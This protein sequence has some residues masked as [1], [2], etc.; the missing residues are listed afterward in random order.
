MLKK[1]GW[2]LFSLLLIS[3]MLLASCEKSATET[4]TGTT[5]TGTTTTTTTTGTTTTTTTPTGPEMVKTSIGTMV[6]KPQYGG[7]YY[8]CSAADIYGFDN[9]Y[10]YPYL[11]ST[12]HNTNEPLMAGDW[13]KGPAGTG[14]VTWTILGVTFMKFSK[15]R[16]AESWEKPDDQTLIIRIRKGIH[17]QNKPP[18]NGRELD[19]YDVEFSL[20][21][22]FT[23]PGSYL[24]LTYRGADAPTSLKATDQWTVEIKCNPG[25]LGPLFIVCMGYIDIFPRDGVPAGGN[26]KDWTASNGTGP[27][28]IT[29]YVPNSSCTMVKNPDYWMTDPLIP[30]N[31]LPY[32]DKTLNLVMPDESMRVAALKTGKVDVLAVPWDVAQAIHKTNPD[33]IEG[34]YL[35][36]Y[37]YSIKMQLGK[38]FP[39][40]DIKVRYAL[41]MA[42]DRQKIKD[43]F[44]G[45]N[46]T[47]F[48]FPVM[49]EPELSGMFTPL[50]ELP[51]KVQDLFKHDV[52][53]AKQLMAEAGQEKGFE[54]E[55]IVTSASQTQVDLLSLIASMWKDINVTLNVKPLENAVFTSQANAKSFKHMIYNYCGN[56]APYKMNDWRPLNPNNAGNID[57]PQLVEVY[58]QL[59]TLYPFDEAGAMA[60][61]KAQTPYILE[62]CWEI[63]PPLADVFWFCQPW[64]KNYHGEVTCGYYQSTNCNMFRWI[65]QKLK[66]QLKK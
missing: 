14:D 47:D 65:D 19:A 9:A 46:A 22:C 66:T 52:T 11:L 50:S 32:I 8:T 63:T 44:Y 16:V 35:N 5:V 28:M 39:W 56:S 20:N 40:D 1:V 29:D 57:A 36:S 42:T 62:Q 54:A 55:I 30:G 2:L 12:T 61:I 41:S 25:K 58:N 37:S 21:R 15:M 45:G 53:K 43:V 31:K 33:L 18:V 4:T 24:N 38:G 60:L 48:T 3:A 49:P 64:L 23:I 27:F 59:N 34:R 13:S 6:E 51:Q 10:T 17:F 26:F 7:T